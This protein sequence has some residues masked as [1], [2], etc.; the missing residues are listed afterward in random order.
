MCLHFPPPLAVHQDGTPLSFPSAT[1]GLRASKR[2][3]MRELLATS[4]NRAVFTYKYTL[5][6]GKPLCPAVDV[7]VRSP[8]VQGPPVD[9][10]VGPLW[11]CGSLEGISHFE[12][13]L[14]SSSRDS[15]DHARAIF[16]ALASPLLLGKPLYFKGLRVVSASPPQTGSCS[17]SSSRLLQSQ[18]L[19]KEA[20]EK[21]EKGQTHAALRLYQRVR[22]GPR[23]KAFSDRLSLRCFLV[24]VFCIRAIQAIAALGCPPHEEPT[25]LWAFKALTLNKTLALLR[26]R[27]WEEALTCSDEAR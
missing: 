20:N 4:D 21:L 19:R 13:P 27:R 1:A 10:W 18:V 23:L 16:S 8:L 2:G 26:L 12:S 17:S 14:S 25:E 22:Q 3:P 5:G 7:F 6:E 11:G 15:G 9:L 24:C